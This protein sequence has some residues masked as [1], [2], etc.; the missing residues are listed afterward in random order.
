MIGDSQNER[1]ERN[2]SLDNV[3]VKDVMVP[4]KI[5]DKNKGEQQI[6]AKVSCYVNLEKSQKGVHM[7]HLVSPLFGL[8]ESFGLDKWAKMAKD[9]MDKQ[10]MENKEVK[11]RSCKLRAEFVYF[12]DKRAPVSKVK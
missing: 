9:I 12:M 10:T 5:K 1:D 6:Q 3:G 4:I 7:S 11:T 2:V 8:A